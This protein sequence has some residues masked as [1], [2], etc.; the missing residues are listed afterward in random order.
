MRQQASSAAQAEAAR[1]PR[2]LAHIATR[3][4]AT[5]HRARIRPCW[6]SARWRSACEPARRQLFSGSFILD[7]AWR[8]RRPS[9]TT[10]L[11]PRVE[12]VIRRANEAGTAIA[13]E[14]DRLSV[15]A[16]HEARQLASWPTR[17]VLRRRFNTPRRSSPDPAHPARPPHA[18]LRPAE[19]TSRDLDKAWSVRNAPAV[20][21]GTPA[22]F[23]RGCV[24]LARGWPRRD[25]SETPDYRDMLI[26]RTDA[27]RTPTGAAVIGAF[28]AASSTPAA[29]GKPPSGFGGGDGKGRR[30]RRRGGRGQSG[31]H[32]DGRDDPTDPAAAG[33]ARSALMPPKRRRRNL[34]GHAHADDTPRSDLAFSGVRPD[35]QTRH[36][37]L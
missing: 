23:M 33:R 32:R 5:T 37:C 17:P 29:D 30:H 36:L 16:D 21:M 7:A 9:P 12:G 15:F 19:Q 20:E 26:K 31:R 6:R 13:R 18:A 25:D 8:R 2:G 27:A 4:P 28:M 11:F 24:V 14:L 22:V 1:R 34:G 35:E 10:A 3:N